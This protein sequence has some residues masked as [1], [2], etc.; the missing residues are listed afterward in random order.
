MPDGGHLTIETRH[1]VADE[2]FRKQR[3]EVAEGDY[4]SITVSDTG[5]GIPTE[6]REQIFDPFFTTKE[7]GSGLGLAV[8]RSIIDAAQGHLWLYSEV[9]EGTSFR[10]LL[11]RIEKTVEAELGSEQELPIEGGV[12]TVLL[13]EDETLLRT[14]IRDLLLANGY[15]VLDA[16]APS[17]AIRISHEYTGPIHLLLTDIILPEMNGRV[18]AERLLELRH[19]LRVVYMSGFADEPI[20]R[21]HQERSRFIGKPV[22]SKSVL[23]AV[24]DVLEGR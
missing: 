17:E 9:G 2:S 22:T 11:P 12:E 4:V 6:I 21:N 14:I 24:R 20:A 7:L 1:L 8:V 15:T 10:I 23:R 13:V 19:D 18:L 3:P 16:A 5:A